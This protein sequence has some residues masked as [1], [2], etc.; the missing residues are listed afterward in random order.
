MTS[1]FGLISKI[2]LCLKIGYENFLWKRYRVAD[3][4]E[5]PKSVYVSSGV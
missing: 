4:F 2:S 1:H 5:I 3:N